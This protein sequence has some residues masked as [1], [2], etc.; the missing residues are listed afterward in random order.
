MDSCF[1]FA[2]DHRHWCAGTV[3]LYPYTD[4]AAKSI[5][6]LTYLV[7]FGGLIR[8]LHYWSSQFL[9]VISAVHLVRVVFTGAYAPPR[10]F[11]YLLGMALF[12][13]A[14]LLDFT[15]YVLRWDTGIQWALV[16][17]TNLV[18]SIPWIGEGLYLALVGGPQLGQ[19]ALTRFYAWHIFGLTLL[20]GTLTGWHIFRVRQGWRNS[21]ATPR[22][23]HKTRTDNPL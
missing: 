10:R 21:R 7:P 2:G 17:G 20:A 13:I 4:E 8:N 18:R 1:P 9:L 11:N 22:T 6:T 14:I 15:G 5:Q 16:V 12:V 3:L 23:A 19:A